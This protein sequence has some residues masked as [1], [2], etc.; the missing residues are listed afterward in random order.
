MADLFTSTSPADNNLGD[1]DFFFF[2][3]NDLEVPLAYSNIGDGSNLFFA[4]A[5]SGDIGQDDFAFGNTGS[6]EDGQSNLYLSDD[7]GFWDF[8]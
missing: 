6:L 2:D 8:A 4:D 1:N 7:L 3:T 5:V